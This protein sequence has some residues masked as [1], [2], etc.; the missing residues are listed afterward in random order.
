MWKIINKVKKNSD[1]HQNHELIKL[2][3]GSTITEHPLD[4]ANTL[5]DTLCQ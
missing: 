2:T 4:V 1:T 5:N 3:H